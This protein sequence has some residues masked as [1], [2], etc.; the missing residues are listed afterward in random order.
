VRGLFVL[1]A[2]VPAFGTFAAA[3]AAQHAVALAG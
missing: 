3:W 2:D 1:E